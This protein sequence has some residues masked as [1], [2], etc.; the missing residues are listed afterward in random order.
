[1]SNEQIHK[2]LRSPCLGD[3]Q[4]ALEIMTPEQLEYFRYKVSSHYPGSL[5]RATERK[6]ALNEKYDYE[7][8]YRGRKKYMAT[9]YKEGEYRSSEENNTLIV[10]VSSDRRFIDSN[11]TDSG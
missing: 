10:N 8:G 11:G 6:E 4:I 3:L 9:G 5:S 1:M 7:W 2:L